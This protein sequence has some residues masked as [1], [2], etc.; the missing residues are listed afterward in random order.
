MAVFRLSGNEVLG[1]L[2][3]N[4]PLRKGEA[5]EKASDG[6]GSFELLDPEEGMLWAHLD[7][8]PS[9]DPGTGGCLFALVVFWVCF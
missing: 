6:E 8:C 5:K 1:I 9:E 7:S 2:A 3:I 4:N